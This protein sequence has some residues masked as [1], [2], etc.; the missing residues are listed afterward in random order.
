MD[1]DQIIENALQEDLGDGDH[2]SKAIFPLEL[3]GKVK[4]LSKDTG[5]LAGIPIAEK[6]FHH[7]DPAIE[8]IKIKNDGDPIKPGDIVFEA[9]GKVIPLLSAERVVLNFLQR[10]SGIAT[11]TN[12]IV[13][14]LEGLHAKVLDTRKT[15]PGLREL[16]KYAVR[17]GGGFNH[18]MG[19]YDM[20]LIKDNHI[21]FAGGLSRAITMAKDYLGRTG[22]QMKIEIE[23]RD[24]SELVDLLQFGTVDRIMLDNF[25]PE[26]L[27]DA[28][29]L[30]DGKMETEASGG[31]TFEN[32]RK[33]AINLENKYLIKLVVGKL[34]RAGFIPFT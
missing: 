5:I 30:V 6:V 10:L 34:E 31:I 18:R 13:S 27:A 7:V 15:T 3:N 25:T 19:L 11:G 2:T 22:K 29:K 1:I 16:E 28:V 23:I 4:L 26:D 32:A 17:I 9:R 21:D 24:F 12:R 33:Y 8:M 20:I 14:S